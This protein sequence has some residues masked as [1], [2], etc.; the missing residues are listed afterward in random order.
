MKVF[1]MLALSMFMMFIAISAVS[2]MDFVDFSNDN[3]SSSVT[4]HENSTTVAGPYKV[5]S[6]TKNDSG[7]LSV[8]ST[9]GTLTLSTVTYKDMI[10]LALSKDLNFFMFIDSSSGKNL[11]AA[12]LLASY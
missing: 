9:G 3:N 8:T 1:K 6:I 4:R 11:I 10:S 5:T 2:A 7:S 12:M